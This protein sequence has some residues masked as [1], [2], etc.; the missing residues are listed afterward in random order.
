MN[1]RQI[2]FSRDAGRKL[3]C[4]WQIAP[5]LDN[6]FRP[7]IHNPR[8]LFGPYV[9]T[10]MTVLDVGCGAG[11]ASMGLAELV[12]KE[13]RVISADLQPQMLDMVSKRAVK[14]GLE[15]RIRTHLCTSNRVG[16]DA[17]LDF[18]VA[19]FMLH[20]VP[21]SYVFL[22]ELYNL[23]KTGGMVFLAEPKVHVT[24]RKFERSIREARSIGFTALKR[25]AV[26][27]GRAVLL[28][29]RV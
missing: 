2:T 16:I 22:S 28:G 11:F 20:E 10:G 3:V 13:G 19:F 29:K 8:R 18:A 26:R 4:P 25:P 7:L 15:N 12:G 14:A 1:I 23:L 6:F 9:R 17:E 21:D 27:F 5:L 24:G